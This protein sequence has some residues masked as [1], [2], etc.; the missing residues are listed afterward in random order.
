MNLKKKD[1]D[2]LKDLLSKLQVNKDVFFMMLNSQY[3]N[4]EKKLLN[5]LGISTISSLIKDNLNLEEIIDE[6]MGISANEIFEYIEAKVQD[7]QHI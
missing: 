7:V 2:C 3:K 1:V 6:K 4:F 5:E